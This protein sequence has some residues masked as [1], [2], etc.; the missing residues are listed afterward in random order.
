[1]KKFRLILSI[2][3]AAAVAV[4]CAD[5]DPD[6]VPEP[7]PDPKPAPDPVVVK[8]AVKDV[9]AMTLEE[10][11]GQM[12]FCRPEDLSGASTSSAV[13][14]AIKAGFK[15]IPV[16]GFTLFGYSNNKNIDTPEQTFAFVKALHAF[17]NYPLL[18]VDEEGGTVLRIGNRSSFG[19]QKIGDMCN[20]TSDDEAKKD[21][22]YIGNYLFNLGFDVDFAPVADVLTNANNTV[23]KKRSFGGSPSVVA[24]RVSNFYAG[25]RSAKVEG[26]LKH[27]P[28]HGDTDGDSHEGIVIAKKTWEQMSKCEMVPFQKA[29]EDGVSMI[30]V[31]HISTPNVTGN[32]EPS[33][34]S[35]E[36]VTDRLRGELGFKGV[37]ITDGMGMGAVNHEVE[38]ATI[39]A[40]KAGVDIVLLP[41]NLTKAYNALLDAVKAGDIPEARI[42]ESVERIVALKKA[43]LTERGQLEEKK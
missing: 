8:Y 9:S 21:G 42:N 34:L 39:L 6:P 26:C 12:F 13:D 35:K 25:L 43:I 19:L 40:V 15:K 31:G 4:S 17:D 5:I 22:K 11:V 36:I 24:G 23:V 29:I 3:C 14:D 7:T 20:V 30:M 27:F 1:M 2:I 37:I 16:G 41:A 32:Y 18:T 38:E 28:G 10:K 33:S